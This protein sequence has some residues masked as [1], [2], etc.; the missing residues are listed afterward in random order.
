MALADSAKRSNRTPERAIK[1]EAIMADLLQIGGITDAM[2]DRLTPE[3][4]IHQE[5][6]PQITQVITNGHDGVPLDVMAACPNLKMI[7]CYGVGYDAIDTS[8]AVKR[9]IMVTHTPDVL[10]AEVATT[11]IMLLMACYREL[12]RDEAWV[13]SGNWAAKGNAPLT[14]SLDNQTIGILGMGRIGQ[15]IARKLEPWNPLIIYHTR[16]PKDVPYEHVPD[17]VDM[18]RRCDALIVITPG[19]AATRHLVNAEVLEALGP[20]GTL[21]NVARGTVVDE[22]AAIAALQSGRL[23][24]AG[25]DVFEDEP[26]VPEALRALRNVVLLPHVGSATVETRAAMGNLSVDNLLKFKE[27]GTVLTP[28][29]ECR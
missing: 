7:S 21:V 24:W 23:G 1:G 9:G 12:L 26:Q 10:N 8:E 18:A 3:F 20:D 27:E 16:T 14:R 25:L 17:L 15:E 11:A 5:P 28:V 6:G 29:P 4:T 2:R 13:R 19:G 22:A